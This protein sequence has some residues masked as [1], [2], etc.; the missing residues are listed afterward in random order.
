MSAPE[1]PLP[2]EFYRSSAVGEALIQSLNE[3]LENGSIPESEAMRI[4]VCSCNYCNCCNL[5][6]S[7]PSL[8]RVSLMKI[9]N[10]HLEHMCC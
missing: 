3:M 5:S 8:Y 10:Q 1:K 4:L 9:F 7:I 2:L 6:Y